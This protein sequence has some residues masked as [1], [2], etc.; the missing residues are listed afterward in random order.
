MNGAFFTAIFFTAGKMLIRYMLSFGNLRS[1][2]GTSTSIVLLLLF[3]F[4]C[5]FILYYGACFTKVYAQF[6]KQPILADKHAFEYEVVEVKKVAKNN[7]Q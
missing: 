5:S 3:V 7:E 1:I 4:Y 6:I 2:F